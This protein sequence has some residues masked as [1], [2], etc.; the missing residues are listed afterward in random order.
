MLNFIVED[1]KNMF[2]DCIWK[3][4]KDLLLKLFN[5]LTWDYIIFDC[6]KIDLVQCYF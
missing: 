3:I 5:Y 6:H 4:W 2:L 1:N